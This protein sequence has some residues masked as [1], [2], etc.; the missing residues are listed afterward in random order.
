MLK[1][2]LFPKLKKKY[3]KQRVIIT[4]AGSGLGFELTH[5]LLNDEWQVCAIDINIDALKKCTNPHLHFYLADITN[6]DL[7]KEIITTFCKQHNGLDILINNA[8]VGEGVLFKDYSLENWNWIIDINLKAVIASTYQVLPYLLKSNAGTIVNMASM[9]G[10]ANLPKMSPYNVTKAAIISLSETLNHELHNS[11]VNVMCVEPTF[12]KSAIMQY[13]K[14]DT[15]IVS[16][17]ANLIKNSKLT[18]KDA[19]HTI[20]KKLHTTREVLRFPFSAHLYFYA[21]KL[22]PT[23]YKM[24][25]R[26]FLMKKIII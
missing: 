20:L 11:N 15:A 18:S 16:N 14:G 26:K 13:S 7:L 21:R 23:L 5:L 9:A 4:G 22:L 8:G 17:A 3:P 12:F 2:T 24:T 1:Q 19:A 6:I 10:I 25:I